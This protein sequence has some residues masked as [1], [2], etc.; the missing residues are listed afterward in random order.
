[1]VFRTQLRRSHSGDDPRPMAADR[2]FEHE[3][4]R[5]DA[6]RVRLPAGLAAIAA[7]AP[8]RRFDRCR[9]RALRLLSNVAVAKRSTP[10]AGPSSVAG[11]VTFA[12]VAQGFGSPQSA[13]SAEYVRVC[14]S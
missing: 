4:T 14:G 13:A 9:G 1:M 3:P 2:D 7:G 5:R 8:S 6:D 12:A 10:S 11:G